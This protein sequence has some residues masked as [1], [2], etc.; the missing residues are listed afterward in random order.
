[1]EATGLGAFPEEAFGNL[2]ATPDWIDTSESQAL[3]NYQ[4]HT[5]DDWLK[6]RVAS[7]GP[8]KAELIA[9]REQIR[10]E[11]LAGSPFYKAFLEKKQKG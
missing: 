8:K 1:M 4:K 7:L 5:L 10:K 6:D 11:W 2:P 3:L 9:Q